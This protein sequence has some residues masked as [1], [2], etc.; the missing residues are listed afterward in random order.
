MKYIYVLQL[1]DDCWYVGKSERPI[2]RV[3]HHFHHHKHVA[4][5]QL[6]RV[7]R[8][9]KLFES[10]GEF[11]EDMCVL[12]HMK[13]YGIARVRGGSFSQVILDKAT[14]RFIN[15]MIHSTDDQ[16][17]ECGE[18]GHYCAECPLR[19]QSQGSEN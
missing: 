19:S 14:K 3:L 17:Y 6:H 15:R 2:I 8:V 4:W 9:A 18:T 11:D 16:C 5:L 13:K 7:E 1:V 10:T 12:E